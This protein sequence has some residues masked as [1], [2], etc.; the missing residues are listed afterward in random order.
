VSA[1]QVG[2]PV[3]IEEIFPVFAP[4]AELAQFR[5]SVDRDVAGWIGFFRPYPWPLPADTRALAEP[6]LQRAGERAEEA[7]Q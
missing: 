3:L 7:E 2:R 5:A 4:P 6:Q 1:F